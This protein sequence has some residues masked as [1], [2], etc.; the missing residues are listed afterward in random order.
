M[1]SALLLIDNGF[2]FPAQANARSALEHAV[3]VQWMLLIHGGRAAVSA[4]LLRHYKAVINDASEFTD[5]PDQLRIDLPAITTDVSAKQFE[6]ICR[7]FGKNRS[8]YVIYRRLSE[9]VRPSLGSGAQYLDQSDDAVTG[10]R[11]EPGR[12]AD[13]DLLPACA[14]AA[15]WAVSALELLRRGRPYKA[16]IR[17]IA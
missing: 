10:L 17:R 8:L 12:P 1:R 2:A 4:E 5:I 3:T 11:L 13:A 9:A 15:V 6:L 14:L 7:R 16:K